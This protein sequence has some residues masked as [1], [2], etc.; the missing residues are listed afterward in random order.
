MWENEHGLPR[1]TIEADS[2]LAADEIREQWPDAVVP[3]DDARRKR[4][5]ISGDVKDEWRW[6]MQRLGTV[7]EPPSYGQRRLSDYERFRIDFTETNVFHARSCKA[8]ACG[9]DVD[10]WLAHY[11]TQLTV[12]E[13]HEVYER[14]AG[15][16]ETLRRMKTPQFLGQSTEVKGGV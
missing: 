11:D 4:V 15:E 7:D 5:T 3:E 1:I 12:D 9:L 13:H 8:I 16:P 2:K 10:D 14:A 6:A